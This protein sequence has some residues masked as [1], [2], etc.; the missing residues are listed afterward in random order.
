MDYNIIPEWSRKLNISKP[1]P[2]EYSGF[3]RRNDELRQLVV[4]RSLQDL[5]I[6]TGANISCGGKCLELSYWKN[7]VEISYPELDIINKETQL[8]PSEFTQAMI[9]YY[10]S[11]A[12][13]SPIMGRWI[14]F[15]ELPDGKF[16][17]KAFQSY[18]GIKLLREIGSNQEGFEGCA[19]TLSGQKSDYGQAS[20][21]FQALPKVP[22]M[23]VQWLGDEDFPTNF[24]ILFDQNAKHYLPTDGY[25]ILGSLLTSKL[26]SQYQSKFGS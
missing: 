18:T 23:V 2:P 25:A 10:L 20:Y 24:Q 26:I 13:G 14:S 15:S 17:H 1:E 22:L 11:T 5:A 6:V 16:Y 12:D 3:T 8:T 9:L 21:I 4:K 19:Q 7:S